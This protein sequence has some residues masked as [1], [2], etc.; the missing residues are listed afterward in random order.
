MKWIRARRE[1]VGVD[2]YDLK[3]DPDAAP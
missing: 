1:A 2:A 3:E